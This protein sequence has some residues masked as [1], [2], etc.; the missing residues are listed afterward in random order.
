MRHAYPTVRAARDNH[1]GGS[2]IA[3]H[4]APFS[5]S[6]EAFRRGFT[7]VEILVATV[8]TLLMML[9]VVTVFGNVSDSV[10][11]SRSLVDLN[12]RVRYTKDTLQRDLA[13]VTATM[14]PPRHPDQGEGY[15]EYIE[16]PVSAVI[17]PLSMDYD[18][19]ERRVPVFDQNG[20]GDLDE[21]DLDS[22]QLDTTVGDYDD[23]LMFTTRNLDEPFIGRF[24]NAVGDTETIESRVAEVAWFLRGSTLYRRVL[25]VLPG[26]EDYIP[27]AALTRSGAFANRN[28]Y[29]DYD[30]SVRI[31]GGS[32]DRRAGASATPI[33]ALNSLGDLTK[34]ENRFAHQPFAFPH[35]ARFWGD[36]GLPTLVECTSIELDDP[37]SRMLPLPFPYDPVN[38]A[39]LMPG[40]TGLQS[41][42]YEDAESRLILPQ[43]LI[44]GDNVFTDVPDGTTEDTAKVALTLPDEVPLRD[45]WIDASPWTETQANA[46]W[47]DNERLRLKGNLQAYQNSVRM[48]DVVLTNVLSFDVKAWDPGAPVFAD[49]HDSG[50]L[51]NSP[52]TAVVQGDLSFRFDPME[53]PFSVIRPFFTT[54]AGSPY[55]SL[56]VA[57][58]HAPVSYGAYVDLNYLGGAGPSIVYPPVGYPGNLPIS[59]FAGPGDF[60]SRLA[61]TPISPTIDRG[62]TDPLAAAVYDTGSS[63]YEYDGFNQ[64]DYVRDSGGVVL[65][66][67]D[68][69]SD[70][71]DNDGVGG[72]DDAGEL[73]APPPYA[74]PLRGIQVK[75]RV[76][77]PNSQQVREVTIVQEFNA[78]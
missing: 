75:I 24:T 17:L 5:T 63:H 76:F 62:T 55:G 43:G 19:H 42:I 23:V 66:L 35:D 21:D 47:P 65:T 31:E 34:R 36:L 73:E 4:L 69:G 48:D 61:G 18:R 53:A 27:T 52:R 44:D 15:F 33:L 78:R 60:K 37:E 7:L 74:V 26:A 9:T 2:R 39:N 71:F 14:L 41:Q 54:T 40:T 6:R 49:P 64:G 68:E 51:V 8:L 70:G 45:M 30:L 57:Q 22:P 67:T 25:L 77:D 20:D 28:F 12:D 1:A 32:F 72:V 29:D 16:G 3:R 10:S 11:G 13:G 56:D 59:V 38:P 58:G 50:D 46:N